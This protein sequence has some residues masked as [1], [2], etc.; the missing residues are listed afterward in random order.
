MESQPVCAEGG[1]SSRMAGRMFKGKSLI[2][3]NNTVL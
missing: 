2:F 1:N 3:K